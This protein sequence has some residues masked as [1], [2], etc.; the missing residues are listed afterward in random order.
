ME[1]PG[2]VSVLGTMAMPSILLAHVYI[3]YYANHHRAVSTHPLQV[4]DLPDFIDKEM[5]SRRHIPIHPRKTTNFA[6]N[7]MA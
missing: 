2:A 7:S 5:I 6:S 4:S 1:E 3:W